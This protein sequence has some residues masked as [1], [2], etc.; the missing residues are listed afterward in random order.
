[1]ALCGVLQGAPE[2]K[3]APKDKHLWTLCNS[4]YCNAF[5]QSLILNIIIIKHNVEKRKDFTK[6][7]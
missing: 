3:K 2:I 4:E 7:R 5:E 6:K 1:M